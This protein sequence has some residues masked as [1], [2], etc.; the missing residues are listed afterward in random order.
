MSA[1]G[2]SSKSEERESRF[3]M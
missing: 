3:M 2:N 1:P